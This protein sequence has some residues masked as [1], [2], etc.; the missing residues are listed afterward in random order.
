MAKKYVTDLE[1][2]DKIPW[3]EDGGLAVVEHNHSDPHDDCD[4]CEEFVGSII[5]HI[6]DGGKGAAPARCGY[7]VEVT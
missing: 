5:L 3:T 2:G 4:G 1:P 6:P 7:T